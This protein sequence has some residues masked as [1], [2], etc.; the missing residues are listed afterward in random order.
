MT[1][2]RICYVCSLMTIFIATVSSF[3]RKTKAHSCQYM[4]ESTRNC[5]GRH[6]ATCDEA[7]E[8][9]LRPSDGSQLPALCLAPVEASAGNRA[10][11]WCVSGILAP[12][13]KWELFADNYRTKVVPQMTEPEHVPDF[14]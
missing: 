12:V 5:L 2:S 4:K 8:R 6:K 10:G 3:A 7:H 14:K 11:A 9:G 1:E 13:I